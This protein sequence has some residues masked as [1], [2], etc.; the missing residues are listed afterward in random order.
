MP[1]DAVN[2]LADLYERYSVA[3]FRYLLYLSGN[4]SLADEL[5]GET[6]YR[7]VLAVDGFRGDASVKTWLLRIARNLYL[8]RAERDRRTLSL[9]ALQASGVS[10][11]APQAEPEQAFLHAEHRQAVERALQEL[12]EN[13]RS[14][15][16]LA[17]V[18][19]LPQREIA[20]MLEMTVAAVKVRLHRAR[21]RLAAALT[22][23]EE[24][25]RPC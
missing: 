19:G 5:T 16:L 14:I 23:V 11:T 22:H 24:G 1:S 20:Q 17:I 7:A 25:E 12:S 13:D 18:E 15:L 8:R 21:Q 2:S 4:P 3:V 10:F 6:F 9:E